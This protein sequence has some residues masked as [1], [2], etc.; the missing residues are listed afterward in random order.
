MSRNVASLISPWIAL[1]LV[2]LVSLV[3][4]SVSPFISSMLWMVVWVK[5]QF[6]GSQPLVERPCTYRPNYPTT[7][8][9]IIYA[10]LAIV[11]PMTMFMPYCTT[12]MIS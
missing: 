10:P 11:P 8:K 7:D 5:E 4:S 2:L 9:I 3:V 1:A 12:D 6:Y